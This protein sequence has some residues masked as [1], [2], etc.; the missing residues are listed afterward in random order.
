MSDVDRRNFSRVAFD[1]LVHVIQN[2]HKTDA[3]LVDL[4]LNGLL[5]KTPEEFSF[6]TDAP[7]FIEICLSADSIIK[8]KTEL[9]HCSHVFLGLKCTS[10]DMESI[11]HLRGIVEANINIPNASER[12]LSE[13]VSR[14][15]FT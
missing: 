12:V 15:D 9:R 7:I 2:D 13:L 10:I 5:V 14:C 6:K 8:M 1:A 3:E 4:S 11:T